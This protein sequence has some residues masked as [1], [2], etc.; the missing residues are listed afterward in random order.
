MSARTR[1]LVAGVIVPLLIAAA[2]VV[3]M[4][5]ALPS[6]PDPVAVHWGPSGA[7]D[8]FGSPIGFLL[9]VPIVVLAYSAFAFA[10]IRGSRTEAVNQR[11]VLAIAP[12]LATVLGALSAGGLLTQ[13]G[14]ADARDAGSVLPV[15]IV[16][17]GGGIALAVAAW[18]FLPAPAPIAEL[19]PATLPTLELASD[20]R[21]TWVRRLEPARWLGI[22][23]G[24]LAALVVGGAAVVWLVAPTPAA[25]IY[26]LAVGLVA[27][28]GAGSLFWTVRIDSRG[29]V[30]RSALGWPRFTVPLEDV[31]G[32]ASVSVD[33]TSGFGGWGVRWA[34]K[35]RLG[36]ILSSGPAL[37]VRRRSGGALVVTTADSERAAALLNS[38]ARRA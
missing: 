6:L 17:F 10:I 7:P 4:L 28:L 15:L 25:V 1:M 11:I 9:L 2:S 29:I 32:A 19:D 12:F 35:R 22:V 5:V 34:G 16:G 14:V 18:F 26:V 36:I 3:V 23:L 27:L 31:A 38:L 37:E 33:P 13:A 20:E 24:V 30:A 21:A 8:G